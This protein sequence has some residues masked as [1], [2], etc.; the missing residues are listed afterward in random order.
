[1]SVGGEEGGEEREGREW[2]S[3]GV[4]VTGGGEVWSGVVV[5]GAP[6][7]GSSYTRSQEHRTH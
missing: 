1:M 7:W 2:W 3:A 5:E 6:V 4:G